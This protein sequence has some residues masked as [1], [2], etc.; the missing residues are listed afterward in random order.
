MP[1]I[2]GG[3]K[4][5]REIPRGLVRCV[6]SVHHRGMAPVPYGVVLARRIRSARRDRELS[7]ESVAA[8]MRALGFDWWTRQTV[9]STE[10]PTRRVTAAEV[11]GLALILDVAVPIL[12]RAEPI[13]EGV[14]FPT[15]ALEV[16]SVNRLVMGKNDG[17]VTWE[18]D[19][20][21][22]SRGSAGWWRGGSEGRTLPEV[23]QSAEEEG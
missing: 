9:G 19:I 11:V 3:R 14:A 5:V 13:D 22:F 7:Q 20:P 16:E 17:S 1:A 10:K 18:G 21:K 8:R 15:G 2:I 12:L 6:M 4:R 23:L